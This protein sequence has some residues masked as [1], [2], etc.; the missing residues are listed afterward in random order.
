M[1]AAVTYDL[2]GTIAETT[3]LTRRTVAA[4]LRGLEL[5]V[6]GQFKTN[7]E[8]F[9]SRASTLIQEQKST[10]IIEHVAYDPID[11]RYDSKIF[12]AVKQEDEFGTAFEARHHIYN[13]VFTDSKVERRFAEELDTN[14][15]VI[16]YGKLPKGFAIPTPVGDYNPDW[17]IAF[18][19]GDVKHF[20]FVA[21]TKGDLS[22]LQ[23]KEIEKA[24]IACARKFFARITDDQVKYDFVETYDQLIA[25]VK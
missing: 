2:L 11:E 22:S 25:L 21:E 9:I 8:A 12:T 20:Y 1:R 6:F 19:S 10:M 4:I 5:P 18:R 14:A 17:A 23:L 16:V 3:Q 13:F 24:K 15:E 7:P